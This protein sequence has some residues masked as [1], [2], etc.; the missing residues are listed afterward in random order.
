M[1]IPVADEW[2]DRVVRL[3]DGEELLI[4]VI[5]RIEQTA[6][7]RELTSL[8]QR[9]KSVNPT[10]AAK[11]DIS[12]SSN[13]K[14]T[15]FFVKATK[16]APVGLKAIIRDPNGNVRE[17]S[18]DDPFRNRIIGLMLADGFD[19]QDVEDAIGPLTEDERR[20]FFGDNT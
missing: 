9:F 17:V 1:S 6:L 2:F 14:Q 5:N 13:D 8:L 11:I 10:E 20:R 16:K 18:V 7:K 19:F 12:R 15:Q 3:K 4:P